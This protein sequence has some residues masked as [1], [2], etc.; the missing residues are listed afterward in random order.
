MNPLDKQ[1]KIE[2]KVI[3][4]R[5]EYETALQQLSSLMDQPIRPGSNEENLIELLLL[6]LKDYEER[7]ISPLDLDPIEAIKFRMEQMNLSRKDLADLIGSESKVSEILSGTRKL[8]LSMI[9][10]LH[11]NLGI[12]FTSLLAD[13][14]KQISDVAPIDYSRFPLAEMQKRG[15]FGKLHK[16]LKE[17]QEYAEELVTT[18]CGDYLKELQLEESQPVQAYLRSPLHQR[19]KRSLDKYALLAWQI[20]VLKKSA[21]TPMH[22]E[23][24]KDLI[25]E[26]WLNSLVKFSMSKDGPHLVRE[27]LA[28]YGITLIIEPHFKKT[29][30]DG[31]AMMFKKRPIIALTLRHNRIDNFWFVLAHELAHLIK[32]IN[33]KNSDQMSIF[34]DDLEI[35]DN[36]DKFEEEADETANEAL[37]PSCEWEKVKNRIK[38]SDDV[39]SFAKQIGI[40]PGIVAGRIRHEKK[41]YRLYPKLVSPKVSGLI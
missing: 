15:C 10:K 2:V 3:K 26:D 32:H 29:F 6:V 41:D 25:T 31:A 28:Q 22:S 23:Y 7:N 11:K 20:C 14:S 30:L 40:N 9:R 16:G 27:H 4:D 19:G 35:T 37:I 12:S 8:S 17:L 39:I 13:D 5:E 33:P 18:F 21:D 34:I 1:K 24:N 38:S 36:L